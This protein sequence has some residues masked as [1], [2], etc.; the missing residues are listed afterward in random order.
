M[1]TKYNMIKA[2]SDNSLEDVIINNII[3]D[4]EMNYDSSCFICYNQNTDW[5]LNCCN[6]KIHIN[7]IKT[8]WTKK[9]SQRNICP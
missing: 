2:N 7:C 6:K 1:D 3:N 8:W 4:I 9:K 5:Q